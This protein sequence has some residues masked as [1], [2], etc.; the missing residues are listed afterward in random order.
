[1]ENIDLENSKW[2]PENEIYL[3]SIVESIRE[4]Y[5]KCDIEEDLKMCDLE[6][7]DLMDQKKALDFI[8]FLGEKYPD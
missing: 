4:M 6:L 2:I 7:E 8:K 1:M 5:P 3:I